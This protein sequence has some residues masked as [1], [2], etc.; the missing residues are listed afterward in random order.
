MLIGEDDDKNG[1][2]YYKN[3]D[4]DDRNHNYYHV[5]YCYNYYRA[6]KPSIT[7]GACDMF[8]INK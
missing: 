7:I 3:N 2:N 4:D 5:W 1:N 6:L 8:S